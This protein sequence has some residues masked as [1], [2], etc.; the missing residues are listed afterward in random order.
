MSEK[1]LWELF[2]DRNPILSLLSQ[3]L[4]N[5]VTSVNFWK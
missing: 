1:P 4:D 3:T 5:V 2:A